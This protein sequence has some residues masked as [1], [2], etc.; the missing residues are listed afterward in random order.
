MAFSDELRRRGDPVWRRTLAHSF[1]RGIGDGSL[2]VER[3]KFYIRQDYV[4]LVEY[5]RVLALAVAKGHELPEMEKMAGLLHATL[6]TEMA[7]HRSYC[8]EFGIAPDE[9][10]RTAP[11]PTTYA[12]TRHLLETAWSGTFGEI[13]AGLFPCQ[14]GYWEIGTLLASRGGPSDAPLYRRWIETYSS[15]EYGDLARWLKALLDRLGAGASPAEQ[16]RMTERFFLSSRL[17]HAFWE[18]AWTMEGWPQ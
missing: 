9:L 13:V 3:F 10:E 18:M 1:V 12:Y 4:F 16:D 2:P 14:W 8:G 11:A 7:L 15:K 6:A 5:A 17:E